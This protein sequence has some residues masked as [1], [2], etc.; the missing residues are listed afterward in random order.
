MPCINQTSK[1]TQKNE[2]KPC[3]KR[4]VSRDPGVQVMLEVQD[5]GLI[6]SQGR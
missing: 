4:N 1:K 6:H 5:A 3:Y 2:I